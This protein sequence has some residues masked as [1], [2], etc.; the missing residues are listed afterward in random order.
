MYK[1]MILLDSYISFASTNIKILDIFFLVAAE[2]FA[3]MCDL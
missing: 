2:I 1:T 3:A